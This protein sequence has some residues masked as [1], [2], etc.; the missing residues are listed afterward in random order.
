MIFIRSTM[1][2]RP[3][4]SMMIKN[5]LAILITLVVSGCYKPAAENQDEVIY[6][7]S[8]T[9]T[10]ELFD[11]KA[12]I[13]EL[14]DASFLK[15]ERRGTEFSGSLLDCSDARY[16]CWGGGLHVAIPKGKVPPYWTA[17]PYNCSSRKISDGPRFVITCMTGSYPETRLLYSKKSGVTLY[18]RICSRCSDEIFHLARGRGLFATKSG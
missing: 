17:G 18:K 9:G 10:V 16:F 4:C 13:S 12:E 5:S 3:T 1:T 2:E 14:H 6:Q 8:A 11:L 7:G 15:K